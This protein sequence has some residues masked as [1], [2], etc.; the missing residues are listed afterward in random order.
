MS[1][2]TQNV[3][4]QLIAGDVQFTLYRLRVAEE[5][6]DSDPS[7]PARIATVKARL[8]ALESELQQLEK[9]A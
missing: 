8:Q 4:T 7:K 2:L 6:P 9:A 5:M 1:S 3:K